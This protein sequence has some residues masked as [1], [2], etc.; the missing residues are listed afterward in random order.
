MPMRNKTFFLLISSRLNADEVGS[1]C[2]KQL[3][4]AVYDVIVA[5]Y[6]MCVCVCVC[7]KVAYN[8]S[9]GSSEEQ[10]STSIEELAAGTELLLWTSNRVKNL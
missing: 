3:D 2:L 8:A 5:F 9:A 6:C 1:F 10:P 7:C 4:C